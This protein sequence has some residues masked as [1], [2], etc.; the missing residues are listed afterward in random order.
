MAVSVTRRTVRRAR[1]VTLIAGAA[2]ATAIVLPAAGAVAA[3]ADPATS[4]VA[5]ATRAVD[6]TGTV[7]RDGDGNWPHGHALTPSR[8]SG[9]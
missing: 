2:L 5:A 8:V 3:P 4:K 7:V 1:R 9:R 6:P